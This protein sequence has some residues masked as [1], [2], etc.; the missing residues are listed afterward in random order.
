MDP[1]N[2]SVEKKLLKVLK[3]LEKRAPSAEKKETQ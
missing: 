3:I 1:K 2:K